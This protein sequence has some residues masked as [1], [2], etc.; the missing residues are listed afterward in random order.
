M[1]RTITCI[2]CTFLLAK[3]GFSQSTVVADVSNLKN[4]KG[5]CRACLVNNA[6]SF[7]TETS[8][9]YRCI[10]VAIT[11]QVAH[12]VFNHIPAGTYALF[13]FHDAN[14]NNKMDRNFIGI[15]KEGYG[16]SQ[17]RLPFASAPSYNDNKFIVENKGTVTLHVKMRNL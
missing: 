2:I 11:K 10:A 5:V 13:V 4:D 9:P 14:S 12:A 16:A 1:T 17:N 6:A 15:P 8:R 3:I 7:S